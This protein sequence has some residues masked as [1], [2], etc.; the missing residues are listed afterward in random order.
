M[1]KC[2]AVIPRRLYLR[3]RVSA[4]CRKLLV[5]HYRSRIALIDKLLDDIARLYGTRTPRAGA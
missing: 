3:P 2:S 4:S 5:A 1:K